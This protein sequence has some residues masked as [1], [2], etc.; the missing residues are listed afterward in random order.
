MPRTVDTS[1]TLENFRVE[2]N[3]LATDIGAIG[4][5]TTGDTS[6]VVNA[7]N[8]IMDQYFFFQD[9]DYDGSDGATSNTV[10]SGADNAGIR[11][12]C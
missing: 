4:N 6:S 12:K 11:I 7:I 3:N 10:F 9:F 5:L 2:H 8:Y 1:S